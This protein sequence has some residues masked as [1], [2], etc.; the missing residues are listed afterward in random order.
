[1]ITT[2]TIKIKIP[3]EFTSEY[4]ENELKSAGYDVLRWAITNY[5]EEF[6]TL[7]VAIVEK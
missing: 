3:K 7:D 1:M 2:K 4:I 6:Y 5:D